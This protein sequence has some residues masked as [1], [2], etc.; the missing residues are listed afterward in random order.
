MTVVRLGNKG[1]VSIP[2]ALLESLGLTGGQVLLVEST[3]DGAIVLRPA[4]VAPIELY[5][6]TR[7][8]EFLSEDTVPRAL[9]ERLR[10]VLEPSEN[11]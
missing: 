9:E 7:V 5:D 1:Q 3:D 11:A 4:N 10:S 6:D 2:K 8:S